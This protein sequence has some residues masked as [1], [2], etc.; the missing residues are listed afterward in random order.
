MLLLHDNKQ[1]FIVIGRQNTTSRFWKC[2]GK[3]EEQVGWT[4]S[5]DVYLFLLCL[6]TKM[7][8][9]WTRKTLETQDS[10]NFCQCSCFCWVEFDFGAGFNLF[11][12]CGCCCLCCL[13][14]SEINK[15]LKKKQNKRVLWLLFDCGCCLIVVVAWGKTHNKHRQIV[16]WSVFV[17]KRNFITCLHSQ[18]PKPSPHSPWSR[19]TWETKKKK[20]LLKL[21]VQNIPNT[22]T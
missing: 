13:W 21:L 12:K 3:K 14:L 17:V 5:K 9:F 6:L 11:Q 16:V 7:N 1:T 4:D 20:K 8:K 10:N 22:P 2:L 18:Q 19:P 15:G